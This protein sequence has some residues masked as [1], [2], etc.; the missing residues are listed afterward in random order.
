MHSAPPPHNRRLPD[1][2]IQ[3]DRAPKTAMPI[4]VHSGE[5]NTT[6]VASKATSKNARYSWQYE[7]KLQNMENV[8]HTKGV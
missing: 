3:H 1:R 5:G 7:E 2:I 4:T 8:L 6:N